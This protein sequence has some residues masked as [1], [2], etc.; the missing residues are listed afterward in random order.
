[1]CNC[2][3]NKKEWIVPDFITVDM[4]DVCIECE[5]DTSF[6]SGY[7]VNRLPADRMV[8]DDDGNEQGK[9]LDT[10]AL[11]VHRY[12]VID[13]EKAYTLMKILLAMTYM[14]MRKQN[15]M[16]VHTEYMSIV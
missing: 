7:F 15:L 8:E 3:P 6:G 11:N 10:Y 5:R 4:G 13:V 16:M 1:M 2:Q 9:E 14:V 12:H